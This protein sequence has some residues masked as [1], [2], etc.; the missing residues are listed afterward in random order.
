MFP[1]IS[2]E[3]EEVKSGKH[4]FIVLDRTQYDRLD[5]VQMQCNHCGSA[6]YFQEV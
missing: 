1:L 3:C 5:Q 4:S 2:P 6:A